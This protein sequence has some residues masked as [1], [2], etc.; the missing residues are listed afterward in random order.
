M[1]VATAGPREE[2]RTRAG[3]NLCDSTFD[4]GQ[5]DEPNAADAGL[6]ACLS[7]LHLAAGPNDD[8]AKAIAEIKKS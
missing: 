2:V 3:G 8:H 7:F 4:E 5:F 1:I 6:V